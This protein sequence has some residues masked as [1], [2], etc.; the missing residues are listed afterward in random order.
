MKRKPFE[1]TM[2]ILKS[3]KCLKTVIRDMK[4]WCVIIAIALLNQASIALAQ[5][6]I[7]SIAGSLQEQ[8]NT[9][10]QQ[11]Q[12]KAAK[13]IV[14]GNLTQ[15]HIVKDLDATTKNLT[16]QAKSQLDKN[17]NITPEQIRE[18][19]AWELKNQLNQKMPQ[20]HGF[21]GALAVLGIMT[22][23]CLMRRRN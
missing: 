16:E 1:L 18:K 9:A 20:Q 21:P 5:N 2:V 6:P 10:G 7:D 15:E 3:Y 19:A 12:E 22:A 11:L 4:I 13:H 8:M 14:E 17:L 23:F